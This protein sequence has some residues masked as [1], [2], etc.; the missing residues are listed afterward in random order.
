[1][2]LAKQDEN[3]RVRLVRD[4]LYINNVQYI[5]P[6]SDD[7]DTETTQDQRL[8]NEHDKGARPKTYK[9][10]RG[11]KPGY[12][13]YK[14]YSNMTGKSGNYFKSR[15]YHQ[16][17]GYRREPDFGTPREVHMSQASLMMTTPNRF[18]SLINHPDTQNMKS[19]TERQKNARKAT[20]P[21]DR[22]IYSKKYKED[23]KQSEDLIN[24]QE[25]E[26]VEILEDA[27]NN[28]DSNDKNNEEPEVMDTNNQT[29][30]LQVMNEGMANENSDDVTDPPQGERGSSD[31]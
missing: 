25:R 14:K 7:S 28:E 4:K 18:D 29:D 9:V 12:N 16:R 26:D 6:E 21:L 3:N 17:P 19:D 22:D 11:Q 13:E 20:S 1:M 31:K 30:S 23:D 15:S 8:H 10:N 27:Q 24:T 2:K 5:P